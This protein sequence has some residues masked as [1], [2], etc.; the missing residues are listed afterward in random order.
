QTAVETDVDIRRAGRCVD[1]A[2]LGFVGVDA[3]VVDVRAQLERRRARAVR[4][5]AGGGDRRG[6]ADGQ[7]G[8]V[9]RVGTEALRAVVRTDVDETHVVLLRFDVDVLR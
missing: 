3:R 7:R 9:R 8:Q 2:E 1:E 5:L 4:D 6:R